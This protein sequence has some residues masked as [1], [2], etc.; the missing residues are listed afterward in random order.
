MTAVDFT[1]DEIAAAVLA[2]AVHE[3]GHAVLHT[4]SGLRVVAMHVWHHGGDVTSGR[5]DIAETEIDDDQVDGYLTSVV[6]GGEAEALWLSEHSRRS[7]RQARR[8]V[9]RSCRSDRLNYRR[10]HRDVADSLTETA[11]RDRAHTLLT[12]HWD[13][14]ER[15]AVRL[16]DARHLTCPAL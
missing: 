1:D 4:L 13:Q 15:L 10:T 9:Y 16:A 12:R 5:V 7:L 8:Q 2:T 6:A 14:V 11:A 3:A